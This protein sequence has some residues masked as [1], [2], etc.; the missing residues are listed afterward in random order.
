MTARLWQIDFI[1][2]VAILLMVF[3]HLIWDM[4]YFGLFLAADVT[5]GAWHV[6]ARSIAALFLLLVGVSFVLA[7]ERRP[8]AVRD[9]QWM[10]RGGKLYGWALAITAVTW[11]FLGDEFV[12]FGIL[13]LIATALVLAPW[14]WR[15]RALMPWL[16]TFVVGLGVWFTERS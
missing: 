15:G 11:T 6:F 9:R 7:A 4:H 12:R 10:V 8:A 2:G 13:H 14:L 1:R 5:V 16:G 3:Y